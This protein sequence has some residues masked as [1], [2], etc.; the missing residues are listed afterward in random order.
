MPNR[1]QDLISGSHGMAADPPA[2]P[3]HPNS[4]VAEDGFDELVR[5]YSNESSARAV[6]QPPVG[7][8]RFF[9]AAMPNPSKSS[10]LA[11]GFDDLVRSYSAGPQA[12]GAGFGPRTACHTCV[13]QRADGSPLAKASVGK[14]IGKFIPKTDAFE[15]LVASPAP[16][17]GALSENNVEAAP[18]SQNIAMEGGKPKATDPPLS[19]RTDDSKD[20]KE[21]RPS[22][23]GKSWLLRSTSHASD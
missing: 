9:G 22:T 16:K 14:F 8:S 10:A 23:I 6:P 2:Q 12:N 15:D 3:D 21:S 5:S 13:N 19:S 4:S 18:V 7:Q 1:T 20:C 17:H 11:D